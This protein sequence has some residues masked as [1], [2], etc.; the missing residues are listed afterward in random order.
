MEKK[1][2]IKF[3]EGTTIRTLSLFSFLGISAFVGGPVWVGLILGLIVAV[4]VRKHSN[5]INI[6]SVYEW[7]RDSLKSFFSSAYN[8][9]V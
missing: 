2:S 6:K 3:L 1:I 4:L 9:L 7:F 8:T 5:K